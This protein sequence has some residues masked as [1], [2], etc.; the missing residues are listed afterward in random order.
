MYSHKIMQRI[1]IYIFV[2]FFSVI[3]IKNKEIRNIRVLFNDKA[4]IDMYVYI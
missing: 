2:K 4:Q 3:N 1:Y